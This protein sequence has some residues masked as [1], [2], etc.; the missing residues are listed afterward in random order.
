[1]LLTS[2]LFVKESAS[3]NLKFSS[4]SKEY[5]DIAAQL[6]NK[7]TL[8]EGISPDQLSRN[9][10]IY[11]ASD[12]IN[13]YGS[14]DI[15]EIFI[16]DSLEQSLNNPLSKAIRFSSVQLRFFPTKTP[17]TQ[18]ETIFYLSSIVNPR[19][20]LESF[21]TVGVFFDS[22]GSITLDEVLTSTT[23]V[24]HA[25]DLLFRDTHIA[26]LTP[27]AKYDLHSAKLPFI[28]QHTFQ[29]SSSTLFYDCCKKFTTFRFNSI[30]FA[31]FCLE[32]IWKGKASEW[33]IRTQNA[34]ASRDFKTLNEQ[35]K[36]VDSTAEYDVSND[37][38]FLVF[39]VVGDLSKRSSSSSEDDDK[40]SYQAIG[41]SI[42]V[43]SATIRKK[44]PSFWN[45]SAWDALSTVSPI[46]SLVGNVRSLLRGGDDSSSNSGAI[47][48]HT[49]DFKDLATLLDN[50]ILQVEQGVGGLTQLNL[51][52]IIRIRFNHIPSHDRTLLYSLS[53]SSIVSSSETEEYY[54]HIR[55]LSEKLTRQ[56]GERADIKYAPR[57]HVSPEDSIVPKVKSQIC[58]PGSLLSARNIVTLL[59]VKELEPNT[60]E[61][62]VLKSLI[63]AESLS[64]FLEIFQSLPKLATEPAFTL[65]LTF[66][67]FTESI[68]RK[69]HKGN[70]HFFLY[71]EKYAR[72]PSSYERKGSLPFT[73]YYDSQSLERSCSFRDKHALKDTISIASFL[74]IL[75]FLESRDNIADL[76]MFLGQKF[77]KYLLEQLEGKY[78]YYTYT[79]KRLLFSSNLSHANNTIEVTSQIIE[80]IVESEAILQCL[81]EAQKIFLK[82]VNS[83]AVMLPR[84]SSN[85]DKEIVLQHQAL[86]YNIALQ[87][88]FQSDALLPA[89]IYQ[90]FAATQALQSIASGEPTLVFAPT[91]QNPQE[92][93]DSYAISISSA[94]FSWDEAKKLQLIAA[95]ESF[96]NSLKNT[97][98]NNFLE[99]KTEKEEQPTQDDDDRTQLSL[100][101]IQG[102]AHSLVFTYN[103][104]YTV[105]IKKYNLNFIT[106]LAILKGGWQNVTIEEENLKDQILK[107]LSPLIPLSLW[108][109]ALN[110]KKRSLRGLFESVERVSRFWRAVSVSA[111]ATSESKNLLDVLALE[112]SNDG[113]HEYYN[114]N[115]RRQQQIVTKYLFPFLRVNCWQGFFVC[116]QTTPFLTIEHHKGAIDQVFAFLFSTKYTRLRQLRDF[117]PEF[118]RQFKIPLEA[119]IAAV[120]KMLLVVHY[121]N[122]INIEELSLDAS[123]IT[124]LDFSGLEAED[125]DLKRYARKIDSITCAAVVQMPYPHFGMEKRMMFLLLKHKY[126]KF[127]E[128]YHLTGGGDSAKTKNS[129]WLIIDTPHRAELYKQLHQRLLGGADITP[130][131]S[132][133]T[134]LNSSSGSDNNSNLVIPQNT[135][136]NDHKFIVILGTVITLLL[137]YC[138]V[139]FFFF[140]KRIVSL[141]LIST[142]SVLIILLIVTYYFIKIKFKTS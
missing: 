139:D 7:R 42:V 71:D 66:N 9:R 61:L 135:Y 3:A 130:A 109:Y 99:L 30:L 44:A 43:Q 57:I 5:V 122:L 10:Y 87:G 127:F 118:F 16:F 141:R 75:L 97:E 96:L 20:N 17:F 104:S 136:V 23:H 124:S 2:S 21:D 70:N 98:D 11:I 121:N 29:H 46:A 111:A 126:I 95:F 28:L 81:T 113:E 34:I 94:T 36:D 33:L 22:I 41:L 48:V 138:I 125:S 55:V 116:A 131:S 53:P 140:S 73:V 129:P 8:I 105:K 89:G 13:L 40:H 103:N 114:N 62:T 123:S 52:S 15:K 88:R 12:K 31:L 91:P 115:T 106:L 142:F 93:I 4:V 51:G 119:I 74:Y 102:Q 76:Q 84:L 83:R 45:S 19:L 137:V 24:S 112:S 120:N 101:P 14:D 90:D 107:D 68:R 69:L 50:K 79:R 25:L 85:R 47:T 58:Y 60:N 49:L 18:L 37:N 67:N 1:M 100:L 35:L 128:V 63:V 133:T 86:L 38:Q 117:F 39:P 108:E 72:I 65:E 132:T 92:L 64:A 59:D 6:L 82:L 110:S 27:G 56:I 54:R 77:V 78:Y 80:N 32:Q 134:S 26:E